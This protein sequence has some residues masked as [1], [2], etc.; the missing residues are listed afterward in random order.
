[1]QW[2][3]V[4]GGCEAS[5]PPQKEENQSP[6]GMNLRPAEQLGASDPG[7]GAA[8]SSAEKGLWEPLAPMEADVLAL[9]VSHAPAFPPSSF[10]PSLQPCN[11]LEP[12]RWRQL[13]FPPFLLLPNDRQSL[14]TDTRTHTHPEATLLR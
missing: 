2:E 11:Y 9:P 1:M 3:E 7:S 10:Q 6:A 5:R 12:Q 14:P 8:G 4:T 13:T